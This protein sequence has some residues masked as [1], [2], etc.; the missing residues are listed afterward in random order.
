VLQAGAALESTLRYDEPEP[1]NF[2]IR[3]WLGDALNEAGRH[4]EAVAVFED[5]LEHHPN[6]G[7]SLYGLETALRAQGME[8][9]AD[10]AHEAFLAAW[11]RSDSY[12]RA[13][14]F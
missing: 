14:V 11:A 7:W 6:N 8:E 2:S 3:Q 9:E 1:L 5:E 4:A 12:I 10:R 13:P